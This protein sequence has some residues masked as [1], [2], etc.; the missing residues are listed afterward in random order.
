MYCVMDT[1]ISIW[2]SQDVQ[3]EFQA[4]ANFTTRYHK[5]VHLRISPPDNQKLFESIP[6]D[7]PIYK[8]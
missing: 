8:C 7:R 6:L 1:E 5:P 2:Y 3:D 4:L